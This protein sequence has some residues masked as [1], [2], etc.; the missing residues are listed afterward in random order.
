MPVITAVTSTLQKQLLTSSVF[1]WVFDNAESISVGRRGVVAQTA[2]RDGTVRTVTRGGNIWRFKVKFPDGY[3]Y[4]DVITLESGTQVSVRQI[5]AV[6]DNSDRLLIGSILLGNNKDWITEYQGDASD[7]ELAQ[8]TV[9]KTANSAPVTLTITNAPV[10]SSDQFIFMSGDVIQLYQSSTISD[11]VYT[12][13]Y[14]VPGGTDTITVHRPI[15]ATGNT[16]VAYSVLVGSDVTFTVLCTK[17]PTWSLAPGRLVQWS[18]EFEF[19][20]VV[21]TADITP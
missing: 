1:Q 5:L 20:E 10:L 14:N 6:L 19:T 8:L 16:T 2:A 4:D 7:I 12:V 11:P 13:V 9:K 17:M 18:G 21:N 3:R 15:T